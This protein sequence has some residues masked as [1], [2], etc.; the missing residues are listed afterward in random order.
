MARLVKTER[1]FCEI[2][3]KEYTTE[4]EADK[5]QAKHMIAG[6]AIG[7]KYSPGMTYPDDIQVLF[8]DGTRCNYKLMRGV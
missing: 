4:E 2:C 5:C 3:S 6:Q 1:W 7:T 8:K